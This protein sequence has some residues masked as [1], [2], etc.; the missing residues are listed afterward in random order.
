[1]V[2]ASSAPTLK[3]AYQLN[4]LE[5]GFFAPEKQQTGRI[6]PAKTFDFVSAVENVSASVAASNIRA[7]FGSA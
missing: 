5:L 3:I 2:M 1:M 4:L 7:A 6:S